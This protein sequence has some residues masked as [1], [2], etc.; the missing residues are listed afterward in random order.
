[1]SCAPL[2]PSRGRS[3]F[4]CRPS[5]RGLPICRTL[6]GIAAAL[7]CVAFIASPHAYAQCTS[8]YPYSGGVIA[9][10]VMV[11]YGNVNAGYGAAVVAENASNVTTNGSISGPGGGVCATTSSTVTVNGTVTTSYGIGSAR[12]SGATISA[13]GI[14]LGSTGQAMVADDATI[15][16]NGV[17]IS[18]SGG[19]GMPLAQALN[20][21]LI[22]FTPTSSITKRRAASTPRCCW[23]MA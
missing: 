13:N 11:T 12:Y 1:M 8:G 23:P 17:S 15:I 19:N 4:K 10:G 18:W 16:A 14:M 21:G 7:I 9:N 20:G 6:S 2:T 22:Q 5:P 3:L